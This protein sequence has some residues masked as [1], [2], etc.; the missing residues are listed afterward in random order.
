MLRHLT[1][2]LCA[3]VAIFLASCA[4][5]K[6]QSSTYSYAESTSTAATSQEA[7][8]VEISDSDTNFFSMCCDSI[9][10]KVIYSS[11]SGDSIPFIRA[12]TVSELRLYSPQL[13]K[14]RSEYLNI[15][16]AGSRSDSLQTVTSNLVNSESQSHKSST[17][18]Y[19]C[20]FLVIILVN[21]VAWLLCKS[22]RHT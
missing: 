10:Y 21:L 12:P 17:K 7:A 19:I 3:A 6:K 13:I 11:S 8:A 9:V 20:S 16:A 22:Y 14:S 4:A 1:I 5:C 18:I 15:S 2:V